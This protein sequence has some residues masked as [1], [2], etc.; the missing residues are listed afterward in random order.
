MNLKQLKQYENL[1]EIFNN[2]F[3]EKI[4]INYCNNLIFDLVEKD[5]INRDND[6]Y[7]YI[8][9]SKLSNRNFKNF[10]DSIAFEEIEYNL[11]MEIIHLKKYII[12]LNRNKIRAI[13]L[14]GSVS[15]NKF[16]KD[17]D[18]DLVIIH[19]GEEINLPNV[20]NVRR[21]QFIK[22]PNK[23]I[24]KKLNSNEILIWTLKYGILIYD[25]NYVYNKLI[26]NPLIVNF[27]N[28]ILEKRLHIEKTFALIDNILK[29][30]ILKNDLYD[31]IFKINHL[32]ERYIILC[33]DNIPKSRPELREQMKENNITLDIKFDK[34]F[35]YNELIS[36]YFSL[37]KFYKNFI[38]N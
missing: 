20:Y 37:K 35:T 38:R 27:D 36:V 5:L 11:K 6:E 2:N 30:E 34:S 9:Y 21:V 22:F 16:E 1:L 8:N 28:L 10:V 26:Q 23:G 32:L 12:N 25:N 3:F 33:T 29:K 18:I 7:I 14:I 19:S 15:R 31:E 13:F 17:S 24:L 4:K